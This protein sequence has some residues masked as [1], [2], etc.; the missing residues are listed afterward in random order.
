MELIIAGAIAGLLLA[1]AL[2]KV[3]WVVASAAVD[4]F[5]DWAILQF[6]N[7]TAARAV[8]EKLGRK[9]E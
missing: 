9:E 1:L 7:K 4:N 3:I 8:E 6:G 2:L 5:L